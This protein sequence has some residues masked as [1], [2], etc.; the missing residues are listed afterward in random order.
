MASISVCQFASYRFDLDDLDAN[1]WEVQDISR[2][3]DKMTRWVFSLALM[4]QMLWIS[5]RPKRATIVTIVW[6]HEARRNSTLRPG[7]GHHFSRHLG[8]TVAA[9]ERCFELEK[10]L[11]YLGSMA[12]FCLEGPAN[13]VN[14]WEA[15]FNHSDLYENVHWATSTVI[16]FI[17]PYL[18]PQ[19]YQLWDPTGPTQGSTARGFLTWEFCSLSSNWRYQ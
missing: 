13:R 8:R 17:T 16:W 2:C 3:L 7:G 11:K 5:A 14:N 9:V 12:R 10:C 18:D 6:N 4:G 19:I 15:V 1:S